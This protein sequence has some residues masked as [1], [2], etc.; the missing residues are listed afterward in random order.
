MS[1]SSFKQSNQT[2]IINIIDRIPSGIKY[3]V[4]IFWR[5][6]VLKQRTYPLGSLSPVNGFKG[7]VS[8]S[9]SLNF[10]VMYTWTT[11]GFLPNRDLKGLVYLF[12]IY[13][14]NTYFFL[15]GFVK[16]VPLC[17]QCLHVML[18]QMKLIKLS[19]KRGFYLSTSV[20]LLGPAKQS[21][22]I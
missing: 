17:N 10:F 2:G 14:H 18:Y 21:N 19:L 15:S 7:L 6:L 13:T 1:I 20:L 12:E 3:L 9:I 22:P 5:Q 4:C 16:L 8:V 11:D